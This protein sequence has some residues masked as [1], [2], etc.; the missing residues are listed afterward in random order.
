[1]EAALG[2]RQVLPMR[3]LHSME[4]FLE[5]LSDIKEVIFDGTERPVQ[6]PKDSDKRYNCVVSIYRN[7]IADFDDQLML[8]ATGLWNF[9]LNTA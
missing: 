1:L 2:Y 7:H 3:Q 6:L 4:E 9:Y 5:K 8:V